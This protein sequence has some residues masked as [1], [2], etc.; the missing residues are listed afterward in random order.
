MS[1]GPK[2]IKLEVSPEQRKEMEQLISTRNTPAAVARRARIILEYTS[3]KSKK[4]IASEL[5]VDISTVR[6]LRDRFR[7]EGVAALY[8]TQQARRKQEE[9]ILSDEETVQLQSW[10]KSKSLPAKFSERSKIILQAAEGKLN[11]DISRNLSTHTSTVAKWRKRFIKDRLEGLHDEYRPE[12]MQKNA[13]L[14]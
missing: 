10:V 12:Y 11:V 9:L 2:K 4:T 8:D 14:N 13:W 1:R 3:E 7:Q 6:R 5:N